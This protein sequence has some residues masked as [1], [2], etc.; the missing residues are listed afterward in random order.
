M[1]TLFDVPSASQE[2]ME[3]CQRVA[4]RLGLSSVVP[5]V[6]DLPR[7]WYLLPRQQGEMDAGEAEELFQAIRQHLW[8]ESKPSLRLTRQSLQNMSAWES[9]PLLYAMRH[10]ARDR[11][12]GAFFW[13]PFHEQVLNKEITLADVYSLSPLLGQVWARFYRASGGALY[14]PNSRLANIKWP[15]AHAGLLP[16]DVEALRGFGISLHQQ[17]SGE[18]SAAPL[19]AESQEQFRLYF[20]DWFFGPGHA[21]HPRLRTLLEK[22]DGTETVIAEFSQHWL[23]EHWGSLGTARIDGRGAKALGLPGRFLRYDVTQNRLLLVF[24]ESDW[25]GNAVGKLTWGR[26]STVLQKSYRRDKNRSFSARFELAV[27]PGDWS[28]EAAWEIG[29]GR[30]RLPLPQPPR[31]SQG[32]IFRS[33]TGKA[34]SGWQTGDWYYVLVPRECFRSEDAGTL[35]EY[36]TD[37]GSP[38]GGWEDFTLL[39]VQTVDL[40][41]S[42][43]QSVLSKKDVFEA[44]EA[45]TE[46]MRLPSLDDPFRPRLSLVGGTCL[47]GGAEAVYDIGDPIPWLAV[48]GYRSLTVTLSHWE[49]ELSRYAPVSECEIPGAPDGGGQVVSLWEDGAPAD[50]G[51]YR[52]EAGSAEALFFRLRRAPSRPRGSPT[53]KLQ[54]SVVPDQERAGLQEVAARVSPAQ[55]GGG[56]T[57]QELATGRLVVTGW[58]FADLIL[59]V[60]LGMTEK[61]HPVR[62]GA[63]GR[64]P[65]GATTRSRPHPRAPSRPRSP[66]A[67]ARP[68]SR[69]TT[70]GSP[71]R[72]TRS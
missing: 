42:G 15:L 36:Q 41:S 61:R 34:I 7:P 4:A 2:W 64:W 54:V 60:T 70:C 20:L 67:H 51:L 17:C 13:P 55:G 29:S 72:P 48:R 8:G 10:V 37:L 47:Q 19:R 24:G 27:A 57:R 11:G 58:P 68:T 69:G 33:D 22:E 18:M 46:R 35:F 30:F 39:L 65:P 56:M 49:A 9:L 53:L 71:P 31:Q 12:K 3:W 6:E 63:D 59:R 66:S 16:D 40:L 1:P 50:E 25:S 5:A 45:A 14:R 28:S 44:M 21:S 62:L 52:V 43:S 38:G 26:H 32:M 23:L